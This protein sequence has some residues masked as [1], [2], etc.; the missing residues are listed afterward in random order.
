[1]SKF[2]KCLWENTELNA[3]ESCYKLY[4]WVNDALLM[5]V[6]QIIWKLSQITEYF[7]VKPAE[8]TS[9]PQ[10]RTLVLTPLTRESKL[11]RHIRSMSDVQSCTPYYRAPHRARQGSTPQLTYDSD[12]RARRHPAHRLHQIDSSDS[13]DYFE[14]V[15]KMRSIERNILKHT[16]SM[17]IL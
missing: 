4:T 8:V 6:V 5:L 9:H 10:V 17:R 16:D 14:S 7:R 15:R 2:S 13:S 3:M 12:S 1:M 11:R